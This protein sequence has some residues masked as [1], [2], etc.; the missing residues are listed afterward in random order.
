M[1][2]LQKVIFDKFVKAGSRSES[3]FL[4]QLDPAPNSEKLLDPDPQKINGDPQPCPFLQKPL[5]MDIV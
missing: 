2:T 5:K 1:K 4:K 3:A